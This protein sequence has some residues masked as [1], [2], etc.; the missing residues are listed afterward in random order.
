[1]NSTMMNI[2][3]SLNSFLERASKYY[4][5]QEIVSRLPDKSLHRHTY[6]DMYQ[7]SR[8]LA[9][10]LLKAGI[11]PGE[12]VA[13]LMW[14][15]Y[16]HLECYFAV[17]A[18]GAVLHTL[19]L[20]LFADDIAYIVNHAE[21]RILI[22][23]DVLLP[24]FKQFSDSVNFE[25]VVV[26][27]FSGEPVEEQYINYESLIKQAT[28]DFDYVEVDEN[29]AAG[30]CYTS[31]TT[32]RPKGIVYSHRSTVLHA[33]AE[34]MPSGI[35]LSPRDVVCP[36]VPMF[37]VNAWGLPYAATLSGIKQVLPGP[38]LDAE[39]LLNVF[40]QEQ[41]TKTAGVPTI[42]LG[43]L[44]KLNKEPKRWNLVD[45][46]EMIVGGSAVPESMI[47]AFD[48]YQLSVVQVWG[49]T[50]TSPL[51]AV[52]KIDK[53]SKLSEDEQY[54]LRATQG[55]TPPL[56]DM[57]II[58]DDGVEC[59]WDNES[60]GEIQVRG[61]WITGAYY[62]L[63]QSESNFTSDGWLRTGDVAVIDA[64][65]FMRITDRTKDLIKSGGEWISSVEL[66]NALIGHPA[67]KEAAVVAVEHPR[68][69][70]R[71]L[72]CVVLNDGA[73]VTADELKE[74]LSERFVK[75][76]LPN[77]YEFIDEVPKTSTGKFKKVELRERFKDY[78]W[79]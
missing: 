11:Q 23:D 18:I 21:D 15:H 4:G 16:A 46:M 50:E 57:R 34:S 79:G 10:S 64:D 39:S 72:A 53:D 8:A 74:F 25:K 5:D 77:A 49:M 14:N 52:C 78:S 58:N 32:G 35:G 26:F 3:L 38:H 9:E 41:V 54:S 31:G 29:S 71:P 55:I 40:E 7:R 20:R 61:P 12:R 69:A 67:V 42:W 33:M 56:V 59:P 70:E 65:G 6:A 28:G 37:H 62:E 76:W 30:M 27:P 51:A 63:A 73:N 68:W 44:E 1:M 43:I 2:P 48:D 36:V 66:E 19:N 45:G 13:T 22:V 17:P 75:W 60:M 24:L 47:R